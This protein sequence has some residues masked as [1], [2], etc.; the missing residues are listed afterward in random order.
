M[1]ISHERTSHLFVKLDFVDQKIAQ[2]H[3]VTKG[4]FMN[5]NNMV[6]LGVLEKAFLPL[7]TFRPHNNGR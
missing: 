4:A 7:A 6:H 5:A 1:R 2:I 3:A